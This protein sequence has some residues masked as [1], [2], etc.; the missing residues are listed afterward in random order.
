MY[1]W[2][3]EARKFVLSFHNPEH[4]EEEEDSFDKRS[5]RSGMSSY[6][7]S[8]PKP[9]QKDKEKKRTEKED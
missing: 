4:H 8:Q 7:S 2:H 1:K 9:K 6:V 3:F 5:L